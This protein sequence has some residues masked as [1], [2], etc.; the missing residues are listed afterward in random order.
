MKPAFVIPRNKPRRFVPASS[1]TRIR[2]S[3]ITPAPPAPLRMRPEMKVLKERA[4]P[5]RRP[6]AAKST[7]A[8][9]IQLRSEKIWDRRPIRGE[10][11]AIEICLVSASFRFGGLDN[12]PGTQT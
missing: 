3:V 8:D 7:A 10:R 6:P 1:I 2:T 5:D 12:A 11:L 9:R 4:W